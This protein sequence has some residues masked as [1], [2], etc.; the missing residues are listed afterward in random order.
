MTLPTTILLT[1]LLRTVAV[2]A[3]VIAFGLS[4]TGIWVGSQIS[5]ELIPAGYIGGALALIVM[6]FVLAFKWTSDSATRNLSLA[7]AGTVLHFPGILQESSV[8]WSNVLPSLTTD[9]SVTQPILMMTFLVLIVACMLGLIIDSSREDA[10]DLR[11]RGMSEKSLLTIVN[12]TIILKVGTLLAGLVVMTA[13]SISF[14]LPTIQ[15]NYFP[16]AILA[17]VGVLAIVIAIVIYF[18]SSSL[19]K[20]ADQ[21]P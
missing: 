4:G 19:D 6:T 7:A 1:F 21:S 8:P 5:V 9:S 10:T 14:R 2:S 3:A 18:Q 17:I 16:P 15:F 20:V 11:G 13:L 12:Q